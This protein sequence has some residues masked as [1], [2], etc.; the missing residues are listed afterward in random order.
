MWPDNEADLDLLGFDFLVDGLV[1]ALTEPRLL[2]VTVGV[3]GDWGS[4]KSSLMRIAA[5]ELAESRTEPDTNESPSGSRYLTIE[6]SPWQYEDHEDVKVALMSAVLDAIA[7]RAPEASAGVVSKLRAI[8]ASL[9]RWGRRLGRAGAAVVPTIVPVVLKGAAPDWDPGS[10]EL[11]TAATSVVAATAQNAL[12]EPEASTEES[13]ATRDTP[14]G[15][16]DAFRREFRSLVD[17]IPNCDAV[18]VFIDDLDRCL[19]ETVVDTFE[20]IRLFL[21][22]PKTAYVLA[23]NQNVVEAAI[24]SRYPDLRRPDG[25]GI[26]RD[27]L[28]KML[29]LKIAIPPLSVPE[30]ET[31]VNLL[32]SE[33]HL[34]ET[35][36]KKALKK[37]NENRRDNGLAVAFNLGIAGE[38]FK[39]VPQLLADDLKWAADIAPVLGVSLRGNPRQLKRFLN[40]L[41]LKQRSATRRGMQ[42]QLPVLAKLMVLEDQHKTDFQKLFDWEMAASGACGE[43]KQAEARAR[44]L[45]TEREPSQSSDERQLTPKKASGRAGKADGAGAIGGASDAETWAD[46]P[47]ITAW[48]KVEPSFAGIDLRPYFA[49]SRD[50]LSFGVSVSRL[51]PH[52]QRL[53]TDIMSDVDANRRNHYAEVSNLETSERSQFFEALFERVERNPASVALTAVLELAEKMPE[54][55]PTVCAALSRIPPSAIPPKAGMAAVRRLPAARSEV[56][57]LLNRWEASDNGDLKAMVASARQASSKPKGANGGNLR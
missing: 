8:L 36:F 45:G 49:Y 39:D 1:V 54:V 28:E 2:P 43:M 9:A 18:I 4:G 42:L 26:G 10:V 41:L 57:E 52:L 24:D 32:F 35:D 17:Q 11:V 7:K 33:L 13:P 47:H 23:L 50:K 34:P 29:Q 56:Q 27:Y 21:N 46:R 15:D 6:F 53:L 51:A 22:T 20:A 3:L 12:A 55:V 44:G 14:S 19:P 31:Y 25:A 40:N 5:K 48:L 30:A 38:L 37:A 16:V